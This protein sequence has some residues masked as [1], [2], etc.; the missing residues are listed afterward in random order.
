MKK[1]DASGVIVT[2]TSPSG[3]T[4]TSTTGPIPPPDGIP[5]P[6]FTGVYA[7]REWGDNTVWLLAV[8]PTIAHVRSR[9]RAWATGRSGS[10][11]LA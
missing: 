2:L 4:S 10:T 11:A 6:P 8:E 7:P 5:F 1:N 9:A 3:L